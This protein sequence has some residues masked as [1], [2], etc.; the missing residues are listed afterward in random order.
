MAEGDVFYGGRASR[1]FAAGM[2]THDVALAHDH[3]ARVHLPQRLLGSPFWPSRT[4]LRRFYWGRVSFVP[5]TGPTSM[6]EHGLLSGVGPTITTMDLLPAETA[7]RVTWFE[8]VNR[9]QI[10]VTATP[11]VWELVRTNPMSPGVGILERIGTWLRA[12]P[13]AAGIPAGATFETG[14]DTGPFPFPLPH[15]GGGGPL[16]IAWYLLADTSSSKPATL[17]NV[18]PVELPAAA[19]LDGL[20]VRWAD[21]RYTWA[22]RYSEKHWIVIP[23]D[24][25][26]RLFIEVSST[27]LWELEAAGILS[28]HL[29]VQGTAATRATVTRG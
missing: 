14:P 23:Q 6:L 26:L 3:L 1:R 18:P 13:F 24:A 10:V 5:H 12:T 29:R 2:R 8:P 7:E 25:A 20:P 28:G 16:V 9:R 4:E 11:T 27:G 15:G 21:N 22:G 19:P 17:I